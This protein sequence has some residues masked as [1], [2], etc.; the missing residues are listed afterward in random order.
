MAKEKKVQVLVS[1]DDQHLPK[2]GKVV[3]RLKAAGLDVQQSM[4]AIGTVTGSVEL[5]KLTRLKRVPGVSSVEQ[6]QVTAIAPPE[7]D[8]Q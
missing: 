4:E 3:E 2:M 6:D 1:V 8:I 5:A 7:S